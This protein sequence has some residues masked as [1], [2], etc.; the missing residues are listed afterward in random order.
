MSLAKKIA[1]KK[2]LCV[3]SNLPVQMKRQMILDAIDIG[4]MSPFFS[5]T[6]TTKSGNVSTM[7]ARIGVKKHLK[8]GK[9]CSNGTTNTV[10]H[11]KQ[12]ATVYKTN[13]GYRNLNLDTVMIL[14]CNGET[15]HFSG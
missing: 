4:S 15:I 14:K 12:Y 10:N 2:A 5:V 8:G 11:L 1:A 13:Q 6:W 3:I 9:K 7:N